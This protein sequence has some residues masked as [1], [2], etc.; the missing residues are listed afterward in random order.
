MIL[1][2]SPW[3]TSGSD[4]RIMILFGAWEDTYL[5]R[6]FLTTGKRYIVTTHPCDAN[7]IPAGGT[8]LDLWSSITVF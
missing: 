6:R 7:T 4:Q 5:G 1:T 3:A 2:P 8:R